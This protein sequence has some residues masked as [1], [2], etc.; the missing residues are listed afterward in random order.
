T[1]LLH[2]FGAPPL[3]LLNGEF[4]ADSARVIRNA[5]KTI[6]E[7]L[8]GKDDEK[9]AAFRERLLAQDQACLRFTVLILSGANALD[10]AYTF[11]DSVNSKGKALSDFD[12]LKANHLMFIPPEQEA[13]ASKHNDEWLRRDE[14]HAHLFST[15]LR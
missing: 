6:R 15:I 14:A 7:F 8:A 13:L 11:F 4:N 10:R 1:V 3:P 9:K 12:L 2:E 5:R